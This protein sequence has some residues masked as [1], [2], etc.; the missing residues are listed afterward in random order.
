MTAYVGAANGQAT[1]AFQAGHFGLTVEKDARPATLALVVGG[2]LCG[3]RIT[4]NMPRAEYR[5][6]W[7]P[8]RWNAGA[9]K[10]EFAPV[11]Q[12]RPVQ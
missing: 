9:R 2:Q 3:Q 12:V 10:F 8:V 5:S 1:R 7:R 11:S 4:A 6:C